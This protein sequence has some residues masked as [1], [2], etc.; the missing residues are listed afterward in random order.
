MPSDGQRHPNAHVQPLYSTTISAR[1][2]TASPLWNPIVNRK[3]QFP[4]RGFITWFSPPQEAAKNTIWQFTVEETNFDPSI[5]HHNAFKIRSVLSQPEEIIDLRMLG[6]EDRARAKV[7]NEGI[8]LSFIPTDRVY[9]WVDDH[10]W[11]GPVQLIPINIDASGKVT[12]RYS[13]S[14]DTAQPLMCF[15]PAPNDSIQR[16]RIEE[17]RIFLSPNANPGARLGQVDWA[18]I[19]LVFRRLLQRLQKIDP[20]YTKN[21][22]LTSKLLAHMAESI[23]ISGLAGINAYLDEQRLRRAQAVINTLERRQELFEKLIDDIVKLPVVQSEIEA[24]RLNTR[25]EAERQLREELSETVARLEADREEIDL[26]E[27]KK[28]GISNEISALQEQLESQVLSFEGRLEKALRERFTRI[29][30]QS[31]EVLADSLILRATLGIKA[32]SPVSNGSSP[33]ALKETVNTKSPSLQFPS[34][35]CHQ[36]GIA[37]DIRSSTELRRDLAVAFSKKGLDQSMAG[38]LHSA[39]IVGSLPVLAGSGAY[40][41]LESYA[42]V[43]AGGRLLWLPVSVGTLEPAD[44]LGRY[45]ERLGR[46]VPQAGGL[47]DLLLL[48][49]ETADLYVVVFDGINRAAVDAYLTPLLSCYADAWNKD[50]RRNLPLF[51]RNLVPADDPYA[52]AALLKWPSNILIAGILVEGVATV[53]PPPSFWDSC[54]LLNTSQFDCREAGQRTDSAELVAQALELKSVNKETWGDWREKFVTAD[55]VPNEIF[56]LLNDLPKGQIALSQ[57]N[58]VTGA[59]FFSAVREWGGGVNDLE[60]FIL[61]CLIPRAVAAGQEEV[62]LTTLG[63][64]GIVSQKVNSVIVANRQMLS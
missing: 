32:D 20:A 7:V 31:E 35:T 62:I 19:G 27:K 11:I 40:D 41:A 10:T 38:C 57:N 26:L 44:L 17:E 54:I 1:D 29:S 21:L 15:E 2:S 52:P 55:S 33:P 39:F 50:K 16:L 23:E 28:E 5:N 53:A 24:L 3:K 37:T 36:S 64:L 46:F 34:W 56:K 59:K 13:W 12:G 42:S 48:A 22:T 9:L 25:A 47:L 63:R 60:A 8:S 61:H 18:P 30:A 58:L 4:N 49:E 14:L 43:V 45:Q 6:S 51:S